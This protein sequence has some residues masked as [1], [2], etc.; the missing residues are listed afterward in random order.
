MALENQNN[1]IENQN[2]NIEELKSRLNNPYLKEFLLE[3]LNS[4]LE[5]AKKNE[6]LS[7]FSILSLQEKRTYRD[8]ISSI[9]KNDPTIIK[10]F[11][12]DLDQITWLLK[13]MDKLEIYAWV[14]NNCVE[15]PKKE[16]PSYDDTYRPWLR[17]IQIE[18]NE[19]PQAPTLEVSVAKLTKKE[20]SIHLDKVWK[21]W[22]DT[23]DAKN[24][25]YDLT[26]FQTNVIKDLW[27]WKYLY[28][29]NINY[30]DNNWSDYWLNKKA[31]SELFL[32]YWWNSTIQVLDYYWWK[33]REVD[34]IPVYWEWVVTYNN[35][36]N[37]DLDPYTKLWTRAQQVDTHWKYSYLETRIRWKLIRLRIEIKD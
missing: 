24:K 1:D 4:K 19:F 7:Q 5:T 30:W 12:D 10:D 32:I 35:N 29:V 8:Y 28:K 37:N 34:T 13:S 17:D 6:F 23:F 20:V 14:C 26:S 36:P 33:Y 15:T 25:N 2:R 22:D 31:N 21:S 3:R 16:M 9:M 11:D 18:S 27:D